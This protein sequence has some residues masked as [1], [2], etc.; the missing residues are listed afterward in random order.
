MSKEIKY[1][2]F[3]LIGLSTF[4]LIFSI[5]RK[6]QNKQGKKQKEVIL[7]NQKKSES[8][9]EIKLIQKEEKNDFLMQGWEKEEN[10]TIKEENYNLTKEETIFL[11]EHIWGLLGGFWSFSERMVAL[12]ENPNYT[13]V[14]VNFSEEGVKMLQNGLVEIWYYK[15]EVRFFTMDFIMDKSL[16]TNKTDSYLYGIYGGF[17]RIKFPVYQVEQM[18]TETIFL[19]NIYSENGY[20]KVELDWMEGFWHISYS[21]MEAEGVGRNIGYYPANDIYIDP[22]DCNTIYVDFCGLW[23]MRRQ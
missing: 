22:T 16:F 7:E 6:E 8:K 19:D 13:E 2:F 3:I 23:K 17:A 20:D 9:K 5:E 12:E 18:N 21:M 4:F 1:S 14:D 11:E 10:N 15:Q